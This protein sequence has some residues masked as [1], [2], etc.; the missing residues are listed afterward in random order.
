MVSDQAPY[1]IKAGK[2]LKGSFNKLK[3]ITCL[4]HTFHRLCEYLREDN[5]LVNSYISSVKK[6]FVKSP[7]C[8]ESFK[9]ETGLALPPEPVI[10]RWGTW[11]EACLYHIKNFTQISK[12][13]SNMTDDSIAIKKAK[14]CISN[15]DLQQNLLNIFDFQFLIEAIKELETENLRS[16]QQLKIIENVKAKLSGKELE[17]FNDSLSKNPDLAFFQNIDNF[18]MKLKCIYAPLTSTL[19]ERSFSMYKHVLTDRRHSVSDDHLEQ[20]LVIM[21][22]SKLISII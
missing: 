21:F 19:V 20:Y 17:K 18:E 13:I 4:A 22:N 1:M 9:N 10:T 11:L 2:Q 5:D 15:P 6:I 14:K 7:V 3:H 8:I 12:F 16:S